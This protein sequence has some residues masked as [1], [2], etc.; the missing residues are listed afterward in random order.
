MEDIYK[1]FE[2]KEYLLNYEPNSWKKIVEQLALL[3]IKY[4][5]SKPSKTNGYTLQELIN[6]NNI[7]QTKKVTVEAKKNFNIKQTKNKSGYGSKTISTINKEKAKLF[8]ENKSKNN[9]YRNKIE[10]KKVTPVMNSKMKKALQDINNMNNYDKRIQEENEPN[11]INNNTQVQEQKNNKNTINDNVP[12]QSEENQKNQNENEKNLQN[13]QEDE[14]KESHTSLRE[15]KMLPLQEPKYDMYTQNSN[16][17]YKSQLE[18]SQDKSC[19]PNYHITA[20]SL[21]P[22]YTYE[23]VNTEPNYCGNNHKYCQ[24]NLE[25]TLE[26]SREFGFRI[27]QDLHYD[28]TRPDLEEII[29]SRYSRPCY[30]Y[31]LNKNYY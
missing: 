27:L 17:L 24:S 4:L 18:S 26:D 14:K 5:K 11:K 16:S 6:L 8:M 12:Q 25:R 1:N 2:I 28:Y 9:N 3:G 29:T 20:R 31:Q 15:N 7:E 19:N 30:T 21:S 22:T 23:S 13:Q 10:P